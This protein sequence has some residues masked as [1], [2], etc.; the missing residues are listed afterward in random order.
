VLRRAALEAGCPA[1]ELFAVHVEEL[2]RL[3]THWHGQAGVD[4]PGR[5]RAR[6]ERGRLTFGA[7]PVA[8]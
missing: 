3:L 5:V 4:L 8:G 2:D 6:R 7:G 1:G